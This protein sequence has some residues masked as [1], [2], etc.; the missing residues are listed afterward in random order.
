M[1][2]PNIHGIDVG[3]Q[4]APA[5]A[6]QAASLSVI[7]VI[8]TAFQGAANA[9]TLVRSRQGGVDKFGSAGTLPAALAAIFDQAETLVVAVNLLDPA[10]DKQAVADEDVT[11][12]AGVAQLAHGNVSDVVVQDDT[13][14]TTYV[15]GTHFTLDA[16]AGKLTRIAGA[17][18]TWAIGDDLHVDY[19]WLDPSQVSAAD[20]IGSAAGNSYTGLFAMLSAQSVTGYRPRILCAPGWTQLAAT[21]T[22]MLAVADR[23]GATLVAAGPSTSDA[24]ATAYRDNF[25]T[26]RIFIV[27]P[28]T[29]FGSAGALED[30]TARVAGL[31]ARVDAESGFWT[32]PSNHVLAGVTG[33]ER[34][35]DYSSLAT[36]RAQ[37]LNA[38]QIATV[39]RL[40]QGGYR[41]WGNRVP[42]SDARWR[43]LSVSR[44]ADAIEDAL[45]RSFLWALGRGLRAT[46]FAEVAEA[47]NAYLRDLQGRGAILGGSCK[48]AD[49]ALNS[50]ANIQAGKSYFDLEFTPVVPAEQISFRVAV[51]TDR[52]AELA[53]GQ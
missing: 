19:K 22:A 31:I 46:F 42:S 24:D 37:V 34:A 17:A 49:P 45:E 29:K 43:F 52:Y 5:P 18:G 48:P 4:A 33:T 9:P 7:G 40:D 12:V 1:A 26:R 51:S 14:S 35:V 38:K 25:D 8:G 44:T 13:D 53:G 47:V 32:S 15:A 11:D 50:S 28:K 36:A 3:F 23:L 39:V 16:A 2:T 21:A 41:L 27:E 10:A 30:P 20:A 6:V